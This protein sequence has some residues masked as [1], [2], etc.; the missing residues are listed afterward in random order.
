MMKPCDNCVCPRG[1]SVVSCEAVDCSFSFLL[2]VPSVY[3]AEFTHSSGKGHTIGCFYLGLLQIM[4]LQE[5]LHLPLV[6]LASDICSVSGSGVAGSWGICV[7]SFGRFILS[8]I[9]VK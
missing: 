4:L 9:I 7:L 5:F 1:S 8:E 3:I 2:S 6:L